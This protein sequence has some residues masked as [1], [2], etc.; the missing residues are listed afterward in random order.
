MKRRELK[1]RL[2][3][4][5]VPALCR[6][7]SF[8]TEPVAFADRVSQVHSIYLDDSEMASCRES[9]A[10]VGHRLKIRIRWYD[11]TRPGDLAFLEF[12][13][14]AGEV[15]TKERIRLKDSSRIGEL[16]FSGLRD[17]LAGQL[18]EE[19][20]QALGGRVQ[21][22]ALV[23]YRRRHFIDPRSGIRLTVDYDLEGF[24]QTASPVLSRRFGTALPE[25]VVLEAKLP[26]NEVDRLR[27][28]LYPIGPRL[29]RFSKYVRC[30]QS[31]RILWC[32]S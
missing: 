22:T 28:I 13:R 31:L 27:E 5:D 4:A 12:K 23:S 18:D 17:F 6:L 1:F 3:G 10:G 16:P 11:A 8:S 9:L 2:P 15:V 32:D 19:H 7:L 24:D 29:S 20:R 30:C 25:E 26:G 14:R 21:P